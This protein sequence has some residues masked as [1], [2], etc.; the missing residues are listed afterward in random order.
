MCPI[1]SSILG[2]V[3][4]SAGGEPEQLSDLGFSSY[5]FDEEAIRR[6][7]PILREQ[8]NSR[9]L[10]WLDNE[11]TTQKPKLVIDRLSNSY[12]HENSNVHCSARR[13]SL[14][15]ADPAP[16]RPGEYSPRHFRAL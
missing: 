7:F 12:G 11:A 4:A 9:L 16:L 8:V 6:D 14:R 5:S 1:D 2:P 13:P 3:V 15:A 10:I